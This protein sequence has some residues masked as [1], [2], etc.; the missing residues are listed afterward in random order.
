MP[1][2]WNAYSRSTMNGCCNRLNDTGH[3]DRHMHTYLDSLEDIA[4]S[5][6]VNRVLLVLHNGRLEMRSDTCRAWKFGDTRVT[7][8]SRL[9][10]IQT[11][12]HS[13]HDITFHT[14]ARQQ[15]FLS[16]FMAQI[17][18][19]S[20]PLAFLTRNTCTTSHGRVRADHDHEH[21]PHTLQ[22]SLEH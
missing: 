17:V 7:A 16:T 12:H 14:T 8:E 11:S 3:A 2:V 5:F 9:M 21:M 10:R 6:R 13:R 4:L 20:M 1:S 19:A 18:P 15:T 22:Y